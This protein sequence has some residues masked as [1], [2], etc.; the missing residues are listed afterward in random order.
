M[1]RLER[2]LKMKQKFNK[3][4]LDIFSPPMALLAAFI[5][6]RTTQKSSTFN[7]LSSFDS[8]SLFFLFILQIKNQFRLS[9]CRKLFMPSNIYFSLKKVSN[10][11]IKRIKCEIFL[12]CGT[13]KSKNYCFMPRKVFHT[14]R[15]FFLQFLRLYMSV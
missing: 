8:V 14:K 13:D 9:L 5:V 7:F 11:D 2:A 12:F 15:E 10:D 4:F 6:Y 1:C 3:K